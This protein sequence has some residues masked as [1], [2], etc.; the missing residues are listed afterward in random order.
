M[1]CPRILA[2]TTSH[3]RQL[4]L[5]GIPRS[6]SRSQSTST[7]LKALTSHTHVPSLKDIEWVR[8]CVAQALN[9][10]FDP[11]AVTKQRALAKLKNLDKKKKGDDSIMVPSDDKIIEGGDPI[12]F[13]HADAMVTV[14]TKL[15]FGD[16][17]CN[18]AMS[19]A[20]SVSM[21]PR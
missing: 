1:S 20:K 18:A 2:L 12:C 9:K 19:L 8:Q 17:Q 16:Y 11:V 5:Y 7:T 15:E 3:N 10:A 4:F 21:S 13:N 14:A 6:R